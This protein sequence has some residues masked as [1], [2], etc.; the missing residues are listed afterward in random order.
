[1]HQHTINSSTFEQ[2]WGAVRIAGIYLVIGGL[3]I[4][5]S[6]QLA[7]TITQD[8]T[9]LTK[10]S[11][12]KGWG[13]ILVTALLLYSLIRQ[14]TATLRAGEQDLRASETRFATIF[15]NSPVGICISNLSDETLTEVNEAFLQVFGYKREEVIGHSSLA[16]NMWEK[17]D[18]RGQLI[19]K[20]YRGEKLRNL[21]LLIRKKSGELREIQI[22]AEIVTINQEEY[23]LNLITDISEHK[24]AEEALETQRDFAIQVMNA[25]GQGLTVTNASRTFEFVNPAYAKMVGYT[26]EELIGKSPLEFVFPEHLEVQNHAHKAR[27]SGET[28]SYELY[29]RQRDG[30][31]RPVLITGAPRWQK[32][33]FVG[34][35]SVITDLMERKQAEETL[36][37]QSTNLATLYELGQEIVASLELPNVY[38][39]T[40][41]AAIRLIPGEIFVISLLSE[42]RN[43]IEDVYLWDR[44]RLWPTER[45]AASQ[46]LAGYVTTHQ[47]ALRVNEWDASHDQ[48]TNADNFGYE[49]PEVQSL[50]AVPMFRAGHTCIGMMSIQSYTSQMYTQE[51]EQLLTTLANQ[52]TKAI[53]NAQLYLQVQEELRERTQAEEE[54]QK[55]TQDLELIN[56][57]NEA[58]NRG[59][60]LDALLKLL[61]KR[62][63]EMFSCNDAT[64][65][66]LSPD[67]KHIQLHNLTLQTDLIHRLEQV[68][69]H[70]IP[71]LQIRIRE[72]GFFAKILNTEQGLLIQDPL[73]IQQWIL[74]FTETETLPPIVRKSIRRLVPQLYDLLKIRSI[75]AIPLRLE[76]KNLGILDLSSQGSFSAEA[77]QRL[78]W[79]AG[80]LTAAISRKQAE[81]ELRDSR[82]RL[83]NIID[84]A[85]DAIITIDVEQ[86]I[87]LFNAAAEHMFML[88]AADAL[89]QPLSKFIPTRFRQ[90]HEHF[91]ER[92]SLAQATRRT[93]R[94]PLEGI[95]GLRNNGEE[96]PCEVSISNVK[97][98]NGL[99]FTAI[100]RDVTKRKQ[101]E[102]EIRY[103]ARL[104]SNV[105]DAIIS[106]DL[107]FH[108][109]SW[110]NAAETSYG[111]SA[112]EVLGKVTWDVVPTWFLNGTFEQAKGELLQ[113]GFWQGSLRQKCKDGTERT[114][115][116]S[117]TLMYDAFAQ[118]TDMV[119]VNRD[120][121]ETIKHQQEVEAIGR[122][123]AALRTAPTRA[124]MIPVILDQLSILFRAE[125]TAF[126]ALDP[127]SREIFVEVARGVLA[128]VLRPRVHIGEGI[129]GQVLATHS[130]YLNN[131]MRPNSLLPG[132]EALGTSQALVCVPLLAHQ[133]TI[134]TL[135]LARELAL[136]EHDLHILVAVA[137]IAANAL[138]RAGLFEQTQQQLERLAILHAM[139]EAIASSFDVRPTL[140]ILFEQLHSRLNVTAADVYLYNPHS[141]MLEFTAGSGFYPQ[142]IKYTRFRLG[143]TCTGQT[144]LERQIISIPNFQT[145]LAENPHPVHQLLET[146]NFVTYFGIP[147]IS[148]GQIKG[149]LELFSRE[150]ITPDENWLDFLNTLARQVA[151]AIDN[152]EM[153]E[154]IQRSKLELELAYDATIEGWSRVL[155]LR[156]KETEGHSQRVTELTIRLA[157][158]LGVP[159]TEIVHIRR[160]A[161]LH[162]IGKMGI[163][164]AILLKPDKLN[165]EE[166]AIMRQHPSLA[167][168]MLAPIAYLKPALDIPLYHHEKWDGTGYPHGLKGTQ[169]PLA[170]R[171]F[172]LADFWDALTSPRPYRQEAWSIEQ[173]LA[174]LQEKAGTFFDPEIV[175]A[176]MRL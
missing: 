132:A 31:P 19:Q 121:T 81:V 125:A 4:L 110:N 77:L 170:A 165:E 17:P 134:G 138:Y 148:K 91:F 84:S 75:L 103:Q 74:E 47:E 122:V 146:E 72:D 114:F 22:S 79:I 89:G 24:R 108:I 85:M 32:G 147:L 173:T 107:N 96:F 94:H 48:L 162:D 141:H 145:Y 164:D 49:G 66:L 54:L 43:E 86:Q 44:D 154:G 126:T 62:A 61:V 55:R 135:W 149:V 57:L 160:G 37:R 112:E 42:T 157:R 82:T 104:L 29:L 113:N 11:L 60:S 9:F 18:L 176:F 131:H 152:V 20:L 137:D 169:I 71:R 2:K 39:A 118:P 21:E 101:A 99:L 68:I 46:G 105:S 63:H 27:K 26:P 136:N 7:A 155:D 52:V 28:T 15:R 6:D 30:T 161:L 14:H 98:E 100:L 23:L 156:D 8:P 128:E 16:L 97:M 153:L 70:P 13:Y 1:M 41:R 3:W 106:T 174:Y 95:V 34:S 168:E 151:I 51:H 83:N 139:D 163:P 117:T 12:Y 38:A 159:E 73:V 130:P 142:G 80:Q 53:E 124:E 119:F 158:D 25:M 140:Y 172:T 129:S 115:L 76:G 143:E 111:W 58:I 10:I 171:I 116:C 109:K 144:A 166:W 87:V 93:T 102:E 33:E 35:I 56:A 5:F 88:P 50:L 40:H 127:R 175:A 45:Y 150:A 69:R 90:T 59:E 92:Y 120:M 133:Q 78:R 67:E 36:A 167:Y 123:S 64:I 65:Y